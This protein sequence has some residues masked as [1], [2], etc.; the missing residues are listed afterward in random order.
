MQKKGKS[1]SE[2]IWTIW[3]KGTLNSAKIWKIQKKI[4]KR[5]GNHERKIS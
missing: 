4:V 5:Y 2:M 3:K 1:N